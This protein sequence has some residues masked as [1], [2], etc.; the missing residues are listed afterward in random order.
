MATSAPNPTPDPRPTGDLEHLFRQKF[1]EAEVTPRAGLWEQL[2]HELLVEQNNTYR[3]KLTWHRWVAAACLLLFFSASGWAILR[4]WQN[5]TSSVAEYSTT[6]NSS[7]TRVAANNQATAATGAAAA[8]AEGQKPTGSATDTNNGLLALEGEY[9]SA[10]ATRSTLSQAPG[11][12]YDAYAAQIAAAGQGISETSRSQARQGRTYESS[13][14][15]A[16][17]VFAGSRYPGLTSSVAAQFGA[18]YATE[19]NASLPGW[20]GLTPRFANLRGGWLGARPDTLKA[21]LL[22]VPQPGAL[23][24]AKDETQPPAKQWR[25]LRLGATYAAASYNPNINF[26]HSDGRVQADAVTNALR[27]YYQDD[28]ETE[29]RRN[30]RAGLSQRVAVT[31]AYAL[32]KHWTLVSGVEA[33]EQH[34]TSATS[35]GFIDG[36]QVSRQVANLFDSRGNNAF[37]SGAAAVAPTATRKTSYRYRTM[38]VPVEIRYGSAKPGTSLYAK[39]GAAVGLLLG[40]RSELEGS[41]EAA[42]VYSLGSSDSPYRQLQTSV[43]GGAGVRYQPAAASWSLALGTTTEVGLTTLNANPSQR[44]LNQSRPYSIGLEASV[45]FGSAKPAA[46]MP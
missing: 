18:N 34:A 4:K 38:A 16:E 2:D 9:I 45:D 31:A 39:V 46:V 25:R 23:A 30:L 13:E 17:S 26:S 15:G 6:T 22:A 10:D 40:T 12:E 28:A 41:P 3:R 24:A 43:R 33:A 37:T 42:R 19:S 8:S 5:S 21:S 1:A 35:Y 11:S 44:A 7:G 36:R 20:N 32:N 14:V 27:N 29:Y